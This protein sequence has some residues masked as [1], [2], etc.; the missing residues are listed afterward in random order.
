MEY[1][2]EVLWS[3]KTTV[4]MPTGETPFSLTY[5]MEAVILVEV[6]SPNFKI[7]HYN[8]GLNGE[9]IAL[10]LDLLQERRDEAKVA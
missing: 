10:Y 8:P 9:G 7:T 3:Y 5:G 1:I 2:L 6:G 4:R